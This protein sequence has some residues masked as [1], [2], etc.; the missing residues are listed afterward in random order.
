MPK[1]S[2]KDK[3]AVV[4][5]APVKKAPI[6]KIKIENNSKQG[7]I[8]K[9]TKE[10][11]NNIKITIDNRK[12]VK[13]RAIAKAPQRAPTPNIIFSPYQTLGGIINHS[14]EEKLQEKLKE[15][16]EIIQIQKA[17][18]DKFKI[19]PTLQDALNNSFQSQ[20]PQY[21][22]TLYDLDDQGNYTIYAGM[23]QTD[24]K[25]NN[26]SFQDKINQSI[27]EQDL[28]NEILENTNTNDSSILHAPNIELPPNKKDYKRRQKDEIMQEKEALI[29]E[30]K[31]FDDYDFDYLKTIRTNLGKLKTYNNELNSKRL[32]SQV[33]L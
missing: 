29:K 15:K 17:E 12:Q 10:K 28:G 14:Q 4:K 3:K 22:K 6:K 8:V 23:T 24:T 33:K 20:P 11:G 30:I 21:I 31:Q 5:K 25:P 26:I 32:L 7:I 18:L 9:Q 2:I 13:T 27:Q 19:E 16:N 1:K